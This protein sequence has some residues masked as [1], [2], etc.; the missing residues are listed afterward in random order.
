MNHIQKLKKKLF[1]QLFHFAKDMFQIT[2]IWRA[3]IWSRTE[4]LFRFDRFFYLQYSNT[5]F[6][7]I[8]KCLYRNSMM[9]S[10]PLIIAIYL[11]LKHHMIVLF[12]I[13]HQNRMKRNPNLRFWWWYFAKRRT[14]D[15]HASLFWFE[16]R[17]KIERN[18]KK[19]VNSTRF[20]LES[21][22]YTR[23]CLFSH[24]CFTCFHTAL[25][26]ACLF[27][28][29]FFQ[30]RFDSRVSVCMCMFFFHFICFILYSPIDIIIVMI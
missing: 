24:K 7:K 16:N 8:G 3:L 4:V 11:K 27:L 23:V 28:C 10:Q 1:V 13:L 9:T 19:A 30:H 17:G 21:V 25:C 18:L 15:E 20:D 2:P 12:E 29:S 22:A 14:N 5:Q 6:S 26:L